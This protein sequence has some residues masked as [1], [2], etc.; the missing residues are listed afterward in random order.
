ERALEHA[1]A[2][3]EAREETEVVR[4]LA[5]SLLFGS[6]PAPEGIERCED[7][8]AQVAGQRDAEAGVLEAL[9][10]L[11]AMRG[12]FDEA[13]ELHRRGART[14][15]DLSEEARLTRLTAVGTR[16]ELLAGDRKAAER[17][18][19]SAYETYEARGENGSVAAVAASLARLASEVGRDDEADRLARL[20]ERSARSDD[21]TTQVRLRAAQAK[22]LARQ[23]RLD[24][25]ESLA[26]EA[27]DLTSGAEFP[28]W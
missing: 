3:G 18:L 21:L 6:L 2:A 12:R 25:A 7:L 26:R 1:R 17:E 23:G 5:A 4:L 16:I 27:L 11:H 22:V 10:S 13:R 20:A 9:A 28:D 24:E 15:A 19:R 8:L 14:Y